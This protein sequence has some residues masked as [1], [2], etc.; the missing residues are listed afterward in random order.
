M[1]R[2]LKRVSARVQTPDSKSTLIV[3]PLLNP[4]LC[5]NNNHNDAQF[6]KTIKDRLKEE[7][8]EASKQVVPY[9]KPISFIL[10]L[11]YVA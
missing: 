8:G 4:P 5:L 6:K 3:H 9:S 7:Y 2:H 11:A 1:R 10:I